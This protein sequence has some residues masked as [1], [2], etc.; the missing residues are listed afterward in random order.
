MRPKVLL[1]AAALLNA[2]AALKILA[3]RSEVERLDGGMF[4]PQNLLLALVVFAIILLAETSSRK[5]TP[6]KS[7]FLFTLGLLFLLSSFYLYPQNNLKDQASVLAYGVVLLEFSTVSVNA[8]S[9]HRGLG[10]EVEVAFLIFI[11]LSAIGF[12]YTFTDA[13]T[14][15]GATK[16]DAAVVLGASVWGRYK[17]SPLLRGRLDAAIRL[18]RRG[19]AGKIVVTGGTRRFGTT[20]SEVEASYLRENGVGRSDII[21]DNRSLSTPEQVDFVKSVLLDS[22]RMK[23]IVI[24]SDGWHLPRVLLMCR[25]QG[26]RVQG[27]A[28]NYKML[29]AGQVYYRLRESAALQVYLFFGT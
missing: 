14:Y 9:K 13:S 7:F 23:K 12:A 27:M 28:S 18:F 4:S 17:P 15:K 20:E 26:A 1:H 11:G 3:S 25:W 19:L 24:V 6:F 29:L 22:L 16:V 21:S 5:F 2:V 8:F 10:R